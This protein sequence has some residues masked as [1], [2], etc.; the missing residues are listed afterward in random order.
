MS[1]RKASQHKIDYM[2]EYQRRKSKDPEWRKKYNQYSRNW[3]NK[4]RGT[5][6]L[7]N[8]IRIYNRRHSRKIYTRLKIKLFELLGG[9]KCVRC[10]FTD[11]RA[12]QFDHINGDGNEE[13]RHI[14]AWKKYKTYL[15]TPNIKEKLQV[16]C[17]NCNWIKR[18][19]NKEYGKG[20]SLKLPA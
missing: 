17:A 5:E 15:H 10:G 8:T 4:R 9:P 11:I 3:Y 19:E 16:L 2:R 12:L 18:E 13:R 7:K 1:G 6:Q 14:S 20:L